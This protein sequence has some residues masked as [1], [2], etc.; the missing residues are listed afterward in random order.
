MVKIV[1]IYTKAALKKDQRRTYQMMLTQCFLFLFSDFL[2]KSICCGY[3]FELHRQVDTIQMG[4]HNICLYRIDK[5]YTGCN[6]KTMELL[7]CAYRSMCGN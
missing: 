4:P 2:N 3:S 1:S 7:D 5:K 6:L